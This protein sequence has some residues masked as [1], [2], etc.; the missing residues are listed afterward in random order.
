MDGALERIF[1]LHWRPEEA[2]TQIESL[3]GSGFDVRCERPVDASILKS[4][5]AEPPDAVI[6][7]LNRLP[8]QGR[9]FGIA[10]RSSPAT[11]RVPLIFAEGMPAKVDNVREFL[12]DA[13]YAAWDSMAAEVRNAIDSP[14][15]DPVVHRTSLDAY[16]KTPL[17]KKL[18]IKP[19]STV[20]VETPP[21]NFVEILGALPDGATV[22]EHFADDC[23]LIL[24]FVRSKAELENR[25]EKMV[26]R[27]AECPMWIAW[28]KKTSGVDSDLTQQKVREAGLGAG[29][30]DYKICSINPIWSGLLFRVRAPG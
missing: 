21:E 12:P 19:G 27:C 24:W 23:G 28:P 10:L 29:L 13:R 25:L 15:V 14:P 18:G 4:L 22:S 11:R 16:S 2:E 5:R 17:P 30:V 9:D 6:I 3:R 1:V 20:V 26:E 8:S 7:D